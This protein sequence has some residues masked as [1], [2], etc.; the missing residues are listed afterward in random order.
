LDSADNILKIVHDDSSVKSLEASGSGSQTP[1]LS[2]INADG[3]TLLNIPNI[4]LVDTGGFGDGRITFDANEDSDT[5]IGNDNVIDQVRFVANGA[6]QA[7]YNPSG[8]IFFNRVVLFPPSF[9]E[10]TGQS[11][12]SVPTPFIGTRNMFVDNTT[13]SPIGQLSVKNSDGL[14]VSLEGAGGGGGADTDLNNLVNT[15]VNR[16]LIPDGVTR[17]LGDF[18]RQ[19][20]NI[21]STGIIFSDEIQ[22]IGDFDQVSGS[23]DVGGNATFTG[24]VFSINSTTINLGNSSSDNINF[25]GRLDTHIIPD[26]DNRYDLGE[27]GRE[28]RSGFFDGVV[29]TDSLQVDAGST[30]IG[31]GKFQSSL[32]ID[33][34]LNHDGSTIGFFGRTPQ[35]KNTVPFATFSLA[36]VVIAFNTLRGALLDYGLIQ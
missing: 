7:F 14:T 35:T 28:F 36:S 6:P 22:L 8:W 1:W 21:H 20:R 15:S 5:W 17:D 13:G 4:D 12:A 24:S 26:D 16:S 10:V 27:P 31:P 30:F 29:Q 9:L 23:F 25:N 2:N 3:N 34:A 11:P 19:W 18:V 32:E 33:G